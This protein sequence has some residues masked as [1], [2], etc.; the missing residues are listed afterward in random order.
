MEERLSAFGE[1]PVDQAAVV[2]RR[3]I[4]WMREM[5]RVGRD[6]VYQDG[7]DEFGRESGDHT[8]EDD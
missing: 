2:K 7:G 8:V 4:P 6:K 1:G 3:I 5:I